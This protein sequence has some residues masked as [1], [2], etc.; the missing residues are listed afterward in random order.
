MLLAVDIGNTQTVLGLFKGAHL[1]HTWRLAS[2]TART[3]DE[4]KAIVTQLFYEASKEQRF[5]LDTGH[6][7]EHTARHSARQTTEAIAN[8]HA[9]PA[10]E[11]VIVASVVP[12]LTQVWT[13]L[14]ES[15]SYIKPNTTPLVVDAGVAAQYSAHTSNPAEIG[16]DRIANAVA[17]CKLYAAPAI[18]LDFGTATNIDVVDNDGNYSGGIISPGLQTSATALFNSAARLPALDLEVPEKVLGTTTK[19]AVQSGLLY[20]EAAKVSALIKAL[21][22]E[23]QQF[24]RS[25]VPII[26]TG[27]LAPL[28]VP[29]IAAVTHSDEHLTLRGLQLI[30]ADAVID[31]TDRAEKDDGDNREAV[32]V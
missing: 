1:Y 31:R 18:V 24:A 9:A 12:A 27:G 2:D 19:T 3:S 22:D 5:S 21:Q 8:P 32:H 11:Q 29:L 30:A 6:P 13:T 16:A 28:L 17:A 25:G 10:I 15:L 23:D 7:N 4:L 26:A 20:G 14:I